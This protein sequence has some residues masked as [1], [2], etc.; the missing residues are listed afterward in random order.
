MGVAVLANYDAIMYALGKDPTMTG[1]TVL[2]AGYP[3]DQPSLLG[4]GYMAF[5]QG[6]NGPSRYLALELNWP[7]LGG[8]E[9]GVLE[10]L[11]LSWEL[12]DCCY[13]WLSSLLQ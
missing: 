5:W 2:W 12:L 6:L 10:Q 8:S 4:Y 3:P 7:A 11:Y 13:T 1:R 9:N